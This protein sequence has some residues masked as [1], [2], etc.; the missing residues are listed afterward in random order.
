VLEDVT[1]MSFFKRM[2]SVV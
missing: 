2:F 1:E